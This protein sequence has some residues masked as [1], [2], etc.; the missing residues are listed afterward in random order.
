MTNLTIGKKRFL[1]YTDELCA[2]REE[3]DSLR[4]ELLACIARDAEAFEPLSKAYS[5]PKETEGYAELME[6]C[7]R[8]AAEPPY[9]ILKYCARVVELDERLQDIGSKL[10]ISDAATSVM[11]A[12]GAM[13]GAY[14]NVI[15]N[16]R[17]MKDREYAD[18][19][20]KQAKDMLDDYAKRALIVYDNI[21]RRLTNG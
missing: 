6:Q 3:A 16:T 13:Y 4:K 15:V 2:I 1:E 5:L 20:A 19:Y 14:M 10:A 11:L 17:L 7:L 12:H 9:Q 8:V 18:A 21:V